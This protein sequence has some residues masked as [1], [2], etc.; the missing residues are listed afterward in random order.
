ML[1][2]IVDVVLAISA[3]GGLALGIVNLWNARS[4]T[5]VSYRWELSHDYADLPYLLSVEDCEA[6]LRNGLAY[7]SPGSDDI[8]VQPVRIHLVVRVNRR[9]TT[10]ESIEYVE[11]GDAS[12]RTSLDRQPGKVGSAVLTLDPNSHSELE[13]DWDSVARQLSNTYPARDFP[14]ITI[15]L[16]NGGSRN[17]RFLDATVIPAA[18]VRAMLDA[19]KAIWPNYPS[20]KD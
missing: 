2:S 17:G 3:C 12:R 1:S 8:Y 20:S 15:R 16:A 9:G 13:F 5:S 11:L 19:C 6:S 7:L 4:S 18:T 14:E 10:P